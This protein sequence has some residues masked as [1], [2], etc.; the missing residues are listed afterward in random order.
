MVSGGD[1]ALFLSIGVVLSVW[2]LLSMKIETAWVNKSLTAVTKSKNLC[3]FC[4]AHHKVSLS[5]AY[6]QENGRRLWWAELSHSL[7][8][9][10]RGITVNLNLIYPIWHYLYYCIWRTFLIANLG[11]FMES[12][13]LTLILVV[14]AARISP[15]TLFHPKCFCMVRPSEAPLP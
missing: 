3:F 11:S 2:S 5:T 15:M 7:Y 9:F 6:F 14:N 1:V 12:A 4:L 13:Q 8:G 10:K